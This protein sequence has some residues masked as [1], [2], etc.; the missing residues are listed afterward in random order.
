MNR[1]KDR[2]DDLLKSTLSDYRKEPG[3]GLWK[4]LSRELRLSGAGKSVL[5]NFKWIIPV[6]DFMIMIPLALF[7]FTGKEN[8][9]T[10]HDNP[11]MELP[12]SVH[13]SANPPAVKNPEN[14]SRHETA[15][16]KQATYGLKQN[17]YP[18]IP[19][20]K[21]DQPSS[22]TQ[23]AGSAILPSTKDQ[24]SGFTSVTGYSRNLYLTGGYFPFLIKGAL[25]KQPEVNIPGTSFI[26]DI[27]LRQQP[28]WL[29]N[30]MVYPA[31]E[32]YGKKE[33]WIYGIHLI[34]DLIFTGNSQATFG[35]AAELT[36]VRT[37]D[38][39]SIEAGFG[40]NRTYDQGR[41]K[42]DYE[43]YDSIAYYYKVNSFTV[44]EATG[45]PN[46]N[47]TIETVFD[48]VDYF[49]SEATKNT[50]TYLYFP[51]HV[52]AEISRFQ[53]ISLH[54][55]AGIYYS[56]LI[57]KNEPPSEFRNDRALNMTIVNESPSRIA[58]QVMI[59]GSLGLHFAIRTNL[60]LN[61]EPLVKYPIK[62]M[63][64]KR[65]NPGKTWSAGLRTGLYFKF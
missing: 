5:R 63:Y 27:S 4:N 39:F 34:P 57:S 33:D 9:K 16:I 65:Y 25:Q 31:K 15:S 20:V 62:P 19:A 14:N 37:L 11:T 64:E 50:Y 10:F 8:S 21:K 59:A 56:V 1:A 48:S 60:F 42:I 41:F 46:F 54:A 24:S 6:V 2:I 22:M 28:L 58:S 40:I 55:N 7:Y 29:N 51:L 30:S 45:K 43:Q 32:D 53:R 44:D 47:T 26:P 49:A 13:Y 18:E 38:V 36:G 12:A 17:D 61:I 52:G 3:A 23:E 35:F